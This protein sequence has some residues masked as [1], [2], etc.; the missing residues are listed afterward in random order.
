MVIPSHFRHPASR[1][2]DRFEVTAD[3]DLGPIVKIKI[4][5]HRHI[6]RHHWRHP[7]WLADTVTVENI[8]TKASARFDC[9]HWFCKGSARP[10]VDNRP[11]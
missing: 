7:E 3:E 2:T 11:F 9:S 8:E 5:A 4:Y 1:S 6:S 10:V